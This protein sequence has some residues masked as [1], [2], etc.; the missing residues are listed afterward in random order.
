[1]PELSRLT[2]GRR[3]LRPLLVFILILLSGCAERY[4]KYSAEFYGLFGTDTVF[5]AYAKTQDEFDRYAQA[6]RARM[7]ESHRLYDIY[8]EYEGISNLAV[9]NRNAG[10]APLA[11]S[12]DIVDLLLLARKGYELSGGAVNV[13]L[14]PVLSLWHEARETG[15]ALPPPEALREA[16]QYTD[17]VNLVIDEANDTVFLSVPGMSL[18]VG[19]VAKAYAAGLAMQDAQDAGLRSGLLSAGGNV[20]AVGRPSD[21]RA[22]WSVGI[23]D[24]DIGADGGQTLADTVYLTG[25]TVS[26]SGGCQR[27]YEVDGRRYHHI[28]DPETLMPADRYKQVTVIHTDPG[29]A[30]LLS[31]ALFILPYADGAALAERC[32][33]EALWIGAD[34]VWEATEGYK[35]VS[36]HWGAEP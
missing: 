9:V 26:C 1:M 36:R 34:G 22:R 13:A 12:R 18:D 25:A 15:T 21:G 31:T 5:I 19:A 20:T 23:Q 8:H 30:D 3:N 33:A 10:T 14:G 6:V 29:L 4:G 17:I 7:D 11:V 27:Y 24:P 2:K 16:A 32:G 28:I 35:A